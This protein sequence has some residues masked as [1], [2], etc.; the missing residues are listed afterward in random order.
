MFARR[1]VPLLQI[2]KVRQHAIGLQQMRQ[3]LYAYSD[4]KPHGG[5]PVFHSNH[6]RAVQEIPALIEFNLNVL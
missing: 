3:H 6:G 4:H 1:M 2:S 5:D